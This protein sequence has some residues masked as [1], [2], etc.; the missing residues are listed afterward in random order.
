MNSIKG[1]SSDKFLSTLLSHFV[2]PVELVTA[3][4]KQPFTIYSENGRLFIE[5]SKGNKRNLSESELIEFHKL[6]TETGSSAPATYQ[7]IT[8]NSSYL[9]AAV[10]HINSKQIVSSDEMPGYRLLTGPDDSTFCRRV[11]EALKAGY[12]LYG[13]PA[14][15]YDSEKKTV[16]AAQAVIWQDRKL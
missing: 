10:E 11:S 6:L 9:L 15:T 8:F 1:L 12:V 2:K 4:R 14:L 7:D 3:A 13:N 5:N 16:I